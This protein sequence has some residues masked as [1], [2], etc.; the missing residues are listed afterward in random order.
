LTTQAR[1][2]QHDS[3][4][5]GIPN[6]ARRPPKTSLIGLGGITTSKHFSGATLSEKLP[7]FDPQQYA[8][9]PLSEQAE[10]SRSASCSVDNG[11]VVGRN[12]SGLRC[13]RTGCYVRLTSVAPRDDTYGS[14]NRRDCR[15]GSTDNRFFCMDINRPRS[16]H[17]VWVSCARSFGVVQGPR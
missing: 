10:M 8:V 7:A 4:Q 15:P 6:Q 2:P 3:H 16:H 12:S 1:F 11:T 9:R 5:K 13:Q 17:T 14:C